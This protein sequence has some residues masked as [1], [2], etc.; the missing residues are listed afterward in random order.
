VSTRR[1]GLIAEANAAVRRQQVAYDRFHDAVAGY[2]KI[3]RTDLRCLDLLDL[4][5]R[6]SAGELSE[7]T[8]L[9]TGAVTVMLDRLE[10]TGYVQRVRDPG[11][12][13]RVYVEP[14]ELAA[15]LAAEVYAPLTAQAA[16]LYDR[17]TEDQLATIADFLR[18]ASEFY[19]GQITRVEALRPGSA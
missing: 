16:P 5:G 8:G 12:R 17:F 7:A 2:L 18:S 3:N 10:R 19:G 13:R 1:T 9:S 11:D 6:L 14:T 4:R 15:K